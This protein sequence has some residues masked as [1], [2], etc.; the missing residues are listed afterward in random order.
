MIPDA[1]IATT[2]ENG[3]GTETEIETGT[4]IETGTEIENGSE[5]AIE[6]GLGNETAGTGL[7]TKGITAPHPEKTAEILATKAT[8]HG[9]EDTKTVSNCVSL[10]QRATPCQ[11]AVATSF[12]KKELLLALMQFIILYL[13]I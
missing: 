7:E 5:I 9:I 12:K 1:E 11:H 4:G 13:M 6:T 10:P 3:T 2:S 8:P